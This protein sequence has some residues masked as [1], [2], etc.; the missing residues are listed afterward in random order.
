MVNWDG[1]VIVRY[2]VVIFNHDYSLLE[3]FLILG[4]NSF[5]T[6]NSFLTCLQEV[7]KC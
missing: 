5:K 4:V 7:N 2:S 6:R 1:Q 3:L